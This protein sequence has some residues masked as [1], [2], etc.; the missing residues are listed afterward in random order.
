MIV[1]FRDR[2]RLLNI[3]ENKLEVFKELQFKMV[4]EIQFSNG[5]HYFAIANV[6]IVNVFNFFTCE[7]PGNMV[8]RG[9]NGKITAIHWMW[10]DS[11]FYSCS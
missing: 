10:D 2:V 4:S 6:N 8:F 7:N 9:H 3:M 1:G 11:G 5:G